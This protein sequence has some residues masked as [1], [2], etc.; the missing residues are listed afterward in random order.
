MTCRD[1]QA[2]VGPGLAFKLAHS[3]CLSINN[4]KQTTNDKKQT[5]KKQ[6]QSGE[7]VHTYPF[8]EPF[9]VVAGPYLPMMTSSFLSHCGMIL[10][11]CVGILY[12]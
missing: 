6:Q 9:V 2:E 4:Q 12:K 11:R 1:Y 5:N 10:I 3:P 7:R 8:S